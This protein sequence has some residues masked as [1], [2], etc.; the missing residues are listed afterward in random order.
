MKI[1][2]IRDIIEVTDLILE[3]LIGQK[4]LAVL[5]LLV[6]DEAGFS[7]CFF[8]PTSQIGP[9]KS[10]IQVGDY[11]KVLMMMLAHPH[12]EELEYDPDQ[13]MISGLFKNP[14]SEEY[15]E[16]KRKRNGF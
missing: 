10:F 2:T 14:F 15:F 1:E 5:T 4:N 6:T 12:I 7:Q 8:T 13:N 11:E 9:A 16:E 3:K